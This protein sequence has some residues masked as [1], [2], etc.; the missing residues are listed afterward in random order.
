MFEDKPVPVTWMLIGV[1]AIG[2]VIVTVASRPIATT[3]H[4][5]YANDY[6][7][8]ILRAVYINKCESN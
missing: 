6:I 7:P 5:L 1:D 4:C 2:I 8:K 3:P